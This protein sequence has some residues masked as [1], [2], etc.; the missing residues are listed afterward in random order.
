M[1]ATV[2]FEKQPMKISFVDSN[3]DKTSGEGIIEEKVSGLL[4]VLNSIENILSRE[5]NDENRKKLIYGISCEISLSYTY[6]WTNMHY[7][8]FPKYKSINSCDLPESFMS[9]DSDLFF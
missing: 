1:K 8:S 4:I 7:C 2:M 9:S 6:G 3:L 5:K